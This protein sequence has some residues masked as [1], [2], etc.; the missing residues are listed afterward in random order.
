MA[1]DL[2][3]YIVSIITF[4]LS[5]EQSGASRALKLIILYVLISFKNKTIFFV[6]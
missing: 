6:E 2:F 3:W 5:G 1:F 4:L